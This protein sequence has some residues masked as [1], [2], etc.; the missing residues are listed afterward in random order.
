MSATSPVAV[1]ERRV[2]GKVKAYLFT[3]FFIGQ[4]FYQFDRSNIGF[5]NLTMGKELGLTAQTFGFA[6]GIFSLSAFLMQLPAGQAFDKFGPRRWLTGI[7]VGWGLVVVGEGFVTN[8]TQL[9]ILRFFVGFFE[10]GYLPGLY[11]LMSC[12][13]RGR[14]QGAGMATLVTASAC[15]NIFGAPFSGW[16]LGQHFFG[17]SGWRG[18]F[19]I[20]GALTAVWALVALTILYDGP[21][22]ASWLKPEE[23]AFMKA[24]LAE[25]ESEKRSH[26]SLERGGLWETFKNRNVFGLILAF[27]CSGWISSTFTFFI[28]T[29][30]KRASAGASLQTVG[31]LVM[32]PY[33]VYA[34]V[35]Q[36]WGRHADKTER[37]YHLLIPLVVSAVGILLYP[38]AKSPVLAML[39]VCLI[40]AGTAGFF[41]NFWPTANMV[42]GRATIAKSTALINSGMLILS[43]FG[44]IYFGW[45]LDKT[46]STSLGLYTAVGVLVLNFILMHMFFVQYKARQK[47]DA[48]AA[49][50]A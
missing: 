22:A 37:H 1:E 18:L 39:A 17:L 9:A 15:S 35:A 12:W 43:F 24:Y 33:I 42:V 36:L 5:A 50:Q 21:E 19:V 2:L 11:I 44:P 23:K 45:A 46:G 14:H 16:V 30:M 28:P 31:F 8:G 38:I 27:A 4:I 25:Y 20:D 7:M 3:Y 48:L 47:R 49:Q 26:G 13:L 29:L 40:Q 6:S 41:V 10:A 32:G 34:V